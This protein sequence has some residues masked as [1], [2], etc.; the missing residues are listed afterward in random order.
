MV[1]LLLAEDCLDFELQLSEL[2][3][4]IYKVGETASV[5]QGTKF[6]FVAAFAK[7]KK[8][9]V[10]LWIKIWLKSAKIMIVQ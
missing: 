9:Y 7:S 4:E 5:P 3:S 10:A 6:E 1:V 2:K 8:W